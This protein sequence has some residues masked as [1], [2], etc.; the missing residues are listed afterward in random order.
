M[1]VFS[2]AQYSDVV[3]SIFSHTYLSEPFESFIISII[4]PLVSLFKA[5]KIALKITYAAEKAAFFFITKSLKFYYWEA[6]SDGECPDLNVVEYNPCN[7]PRYSA[8]KYVYCS[9]KGLIYASVSIGSQ[10]RGYI[11]I[12]AD[13]LLD[14]PKNEET[15]NL[16]LF[17]ASIIGTVITIKHSFDQEV[18]RRN[19]E[20]TCT[21]LNEIIHDIKN[22]LTGMSGFFQL[23]EAKSTETSLKRFY[24]L[25]HENI[26]KIELIPQEILDIIKRQTLILNRQCLLVS[27]LLTE[28]ILFS[29]PTSS[30]DSE[31]EDILIAGNVYIYG[32]KLKLKKALCAIHEN[33]KASQS[34][35]PIKI[36]VTQKSEVIEIKIE[37]TGNGIP[38]Y[39][40][41]EILQPLFS[42]PDSTKMGIGL[43]YA[44]RII[45]LH[46]GSL[47]IDSVYQR[48]TSVCIQ[49]PLY[50]KEDCE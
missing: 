19:Q 30:K 33:A 13:N 6:E 48:G 20:C 9:K 10:E 39:I 36:F 15:I 46:G 44:E 28:S 24:S 18:L 1:V 27:D 31:E 3:S 7:D 37:D 32:D 43:S 14:S 22:P 42:F 12:K 50:S 49:L 5:E 47:L 4:R 41:G 17:C 26:K 29:A 35:G 21:L 45:A 23:I 16:A 34:K 40:K 2:S 38:I 11:C 25:I 8:Q